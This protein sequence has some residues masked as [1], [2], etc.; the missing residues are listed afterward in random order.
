VAAV[1]RFA[2]V[3][4]G[5]VSEFSRES[6]KVRLAATLPGIVAEDITLNVTA[7]SVLVTSVIAVTSDEVANST[8]SSLRAFTPETLSAALGGVTVETISP[9]TVTRGDAAIDGA[10]DGVSNVPSSDQTAA[11]IEPT[12]GEVLMENLVLV[13][14]L[15]VVLVLLVIS[16]VLCYCCCCRA[17][18]PSRRQ[19]T[20]QTTTIGQSTLDTMGSIDLTAVN[21][22]AT[23]STAAA[24]A[25]TALERV[26][27]ANANAGARGALERARAAKA[28]KSDVSDGAVFGAAE[29]V[30]AEDVE[31]DDPRLR[32]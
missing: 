21:H 6:F 28:A 16:L 17:S 26:R 2:T 1:V 22:Y 31:E 10:A 32:L 4:S 25:G 20:I 13:I 27:I 23:S 8:L 18:K 14:I 3:L 24:T 7:A 12:I 19:R 29:Q 11:N 30:V 9:P 15:A 5:S